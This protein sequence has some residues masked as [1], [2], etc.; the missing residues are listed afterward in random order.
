MK[1]KSFIDIFEQIDKD[2]DLEVDWQEFLNFFVYESN[3]DTANE[4]KM[5]LQAIVKRSQYLLGQMKIQ[6]R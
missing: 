1:I 5:L 6:S 4:S 2:A 3:K